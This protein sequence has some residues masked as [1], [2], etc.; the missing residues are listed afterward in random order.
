MFTNSKCLTDRL[1]TI[2]ELIAKLALTRCGDFNFFPQK[3]DF[4]SVE[5]PTY[6]LQAGFF[7]GTTGACKRIREGQSSLIQLQHPVANQMI[8]LLWNFIMGTVPC[9]QVMFLQG[10][11]VGAK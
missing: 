1:L 4:V 6:E 9:L 11:I 10:L 5:S 2:L 8:D 3:A 7:I